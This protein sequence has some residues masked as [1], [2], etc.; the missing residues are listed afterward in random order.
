[1]SLRLALPLALA[2]LPLAAQQRQLSL[3]EYREELLRI[4]DARDAGALEQARADAAALLEARVVA[5]GETLSPD[6]TLLGP[7]AAADGASQ[8]PASQARSLRLLA[9]A[10]A[11]T[12]AA[13]TALPDQQLLRRLAAEQTPQ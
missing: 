10:L 5:D 9:E 8:Q 6:V 3:Q 1:M 13:A 12:D 11:A 2:A 4:A 7:L